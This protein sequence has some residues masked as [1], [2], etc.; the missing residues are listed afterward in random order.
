MPP[1]KETII[2]PSKTLFGARLSYVLG[3]MGIKQVEFR[4]RLNAHYYHRD[5][6]R[7]LVSRWMSGERDPTPYLKEIVEVLRGEL[8]NFFNT[9]GSPRDYGLVR[10]P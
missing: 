2:V 4:Q 9:A 8:K 1:T 5:V 10:S 7:S 3:Q 6:S